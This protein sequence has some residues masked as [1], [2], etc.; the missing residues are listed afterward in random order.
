M[1]LAAPQPIDGQRLTLDASIGISLYPDDGEDLSALGGY[2]DA[3]MYR[4]KRTRAP[5]FAHHSDAGIDT[6]RPGSPQ[7][8]VV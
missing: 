4:A 1:A 2:A 6:A 3:A 8:P 7:D 5:G